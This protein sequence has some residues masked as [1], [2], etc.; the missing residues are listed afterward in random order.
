MFIINQL[1]I[2]PLAESEVLHGDEVGVVA[3][4]GDEFVVGAALHDASFVHHANKVGIPDGAEAV[5]IDARP[6]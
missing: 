1:R 2:A 4:K 3:A 6:F 5:G